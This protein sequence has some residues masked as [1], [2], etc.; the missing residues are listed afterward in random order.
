MMSAKPWDSSLLPLDTDDELDASSLFTLEEP[1]L[2]TPQGAES[3]YKLGKHFETDEQ[4][5][6]WRSTVEKL[7]G[8]FEQSTPKP[9]PPARASSALMG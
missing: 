2:D 1:I 5:Q 3:L 6:A 4:R 9:P 8:F 7:A